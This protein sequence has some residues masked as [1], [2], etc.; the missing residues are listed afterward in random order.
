MKLFKKMLD[1]MS[2][3][4]G[5]AIPGQAQIIIGYIVTLLGVSLMFGSNSIFGFIFWVAFIIFGVWLIRNGTE[6]KRVMQRMNMYRHFISE[7]DMTV[8]RELAD[9]VGKPVYLVRKDLQRLVD[10]NHLR[11]AW[12]NPATD[13]VG[14][15]GKHSPTVQANPVQVDAEDSVD[16]KVELVCKACDAKAIVDK[17]KQI[18]CEYCGSLVR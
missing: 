14:F 13:E 16:L 10:H 1:K 5:N 2:D 8:I 4:I 9:K 12:I 18:I 7:Y 6:T 11:N 17:G 15:H 3:E